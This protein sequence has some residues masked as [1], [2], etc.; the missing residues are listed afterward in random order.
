MEQDIW[1]DFEDGN[2]Y[3]SKVREREWRKLQTQFVNE[4]F[5]DGID[6]GK[7]S[8]LQEGFNQG[9][10]EGSTTGIKFGRM[11]GVISSF[12]LF[13]SHHPDICSESLQT[14]ISNLN[15]KLSAISE[16]RTRAYISSDIERA[17]R[18]AEEVKTHLHNFIEK[19]L[20]I[21][22][23]KQDSSTTDKDFIF[24][25]IESVLLPAEEQGILKSTF[26]E[27]FSK[28]LPFLNDS[29]RIASIAKKVLVAIASEC[30]QKEVFMLLSEHLDINSDEKTTQ[31]LLE[32]IK[33]VLLRFPATNRGRFMESVF[34]PIFRL[35][36]VKKRSKETVEQVGTK[37]LSFELHGS[38]LEETDFKSVPIPQL[39]AF[40]EPRCESCR[41]LSISKRKRNSR[42]ISKTTIVLTSL[43]HQ[44]L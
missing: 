44:N 28:F 14:E 25:I 9:F 22:V 16:E 31:I 40:F 15:D 39:Q 18:C 7:E 6:L 1:E 30:N 4:G 33:I 20:E 19:N 42:V 3:E 8:V 43:H 32:L 26:F 23:S 38:G 36:E 27:L 12:D 37:A 35:I 5:R 34:P 17:D 13:I 41:I 24:Q 21:F 11:I 2:Q 29:E 10:K